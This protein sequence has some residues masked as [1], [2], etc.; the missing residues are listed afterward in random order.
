[1][2][3]H[4]VFFLV[5][6]GAFVVR[7]NAREL[8]AMNELVAAGKVIPVVGQVFSLRDGAAAVAAFART[9]RSRVCVHCCSNAAGSDSSA[10]ATAIFTSATSC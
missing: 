5:V 4:Q 3:S 2:A 7:E 6:I 10:A 1:M 9:R 8:L